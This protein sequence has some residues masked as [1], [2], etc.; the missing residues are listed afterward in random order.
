MEEH[1]QFVDG[2]DVAAMRPE[3]N[4]K[5]VDL[6]NEEFHADSAND[7]TQNAREVARHDHKTGRRE[8]RLLSLRANAKKKTLPGKNFHPLKGRFR[9][10]G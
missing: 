7:L 3:K 6:V 4:E 10:E 9:T 5:L 1:A 2:L 8:K